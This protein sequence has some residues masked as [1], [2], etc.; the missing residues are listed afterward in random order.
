MC[1]FQDLDMEICKVKYS[2]FCDFLTQFE[3][4]T[5]LQC[6]STTH[7]HAPHKP[8]AVRKYS[9]H[10][11]HI[12]HCPNNLPRNSFDGR[13]STTV[14]NPNVDFP[15]TE[16]A[17]KLALIPIFGGLLREVLL[18]TADLVATAAIVVAVLDDTADLFV[19]AAVAAVAAPAG[20]DNVVDLFV[21]AA[22]TVVD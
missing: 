18:A 16:I 7:P 5:I 22:S 15:A 8:S 2:T 21:V 17:G 19:T 12:L 13:S 20:V 9:S 11:A 10:S 3:L 1:Y 4:C 6:F 14:A